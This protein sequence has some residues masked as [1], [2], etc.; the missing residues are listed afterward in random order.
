MACVQ[1]YIGDGKGKTTA[2]FGLALRMSGTGKKVVIVQLLKN[3]DSGEITA[4]CRLPNVSYVPVTKKFGF[5][6]L[7]SEE[8]KKEAKAYYTGLL[9]VAIDTAIQERADLLVVD[10]LIDAYGLDMIDKE[11]W[12][13]FVKN[14]PENLEI[15]MTGR[16]PAPELLEL[17]DYVSE[18]KKV[19]HPF[20]K[21]QP[22]RKGIE[23]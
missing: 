18:V 17:S 10:E 19:K 5:V 23:Y 12:L 8:E 15:V 20:D 4:I 21:G 22:A 3:G 1:I 13:E 11:E 2:A 6:F 16:N 9:K 7:M 14:R